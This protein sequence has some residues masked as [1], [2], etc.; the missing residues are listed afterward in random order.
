VKQSKNF[1]AEQYRNSFSYLAKA[2]L[3]LK[4]GYQQPGL[5]MELLVYNLIKK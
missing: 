2:D 4:T 1:S 3:H 5:V